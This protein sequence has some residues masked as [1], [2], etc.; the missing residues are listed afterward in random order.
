MREICF[1]ITGRALF[2]RSCEYRH[3]IKD[4][5][6]EKPKSVQYAR[7]SHRVGWKEARISEILPQMTIAG[8]KLFLQHKNLQIIPIH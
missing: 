4:S 8:S 5:L 3:T 1:S 6:L 7:K 2:A